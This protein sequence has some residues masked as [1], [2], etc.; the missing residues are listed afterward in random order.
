MSANPTCRVLIIG[1]GL[2]G[3][4]SAIAITLAGHEAL[5]FERMPVLREV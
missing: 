5:I 3:L 2:A 4:A 1:G